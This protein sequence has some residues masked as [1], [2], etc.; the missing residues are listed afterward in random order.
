M[1]GLERY[2]SDRRMVALLCRKRVALASKNHHDHF[3]T[4]VAGIP[5]SRQSKAPDHEELQELLPPR[6]YWP[7]ARRRIRRESQD[8]SA[9]TA[10]TLARYVVRVL[11]EDAGAYAW[12]KRL[13]G[14]LDRARRSALSWNNSMVHNP[15]RILPIPKDRRGGG[16]KYRVV[17]T[18][19]LGD[20]VIASG[21]AA[22]LG[23]AID[24]ALGDFCFGSRP[25][26]DGRSRKHHDAVRGFRTFASQIPEKTDLWAAECDII[27]FFDSVPHKVALGK[28]RSISAKA[29][30]TLDDRAIA[31]LNSFLAGYDYISAR[32]EALTTLRARHVS[33]PILFDLKTALAEAG[34]ETN[35]QERRG[36]P[37]G[38]PLSGV[39][40]NAVLASADEACLKR[41]RGEGR[42][43]YGRF[44]DD[45]LLVST[46]RDSCRLALRAYRHE[47]RRLGLA[48][49]RAVKVHPYHGK[50]MKRFWEGKSKHPYL[51]RAGEHGSGVPWIGFLGYQFKRDGTLRI[52]RTSIQREIAKQMQVVNDV[53]GMIRRAHAE[54]AASRKHYR[55]P[56][57][58][59]I[60]HGVLMHLI[61]MGVGRPPRHRTSPSP[62][63]LCWCKGF[64]LLQNGPVALEPLKDLDRGRTSAMKTL[65]GKLITV[66]DGFTRCGPG[67]IAPQHAF[68]RHGVR[69]PH[70]LRYAGHTLS[71]Y[72][73]FSAVRKSCEGPRRQR[74]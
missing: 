36:I 5:A 1:F 56:A 68:E 51:W 54:A 38:S 50:G 61:A 27:G 33:A 73:Q 69:R 55:V 29:G 6:R 26:H 35:V 13:R 43:H 20:S 7:R 44:F 23:D 21:F 34:I 19:S 64:P 41:L 70:S 72:G 32:K 16:Q 46:K 40:A 39:I 63:S 47:L 8:R 2:F 74:E 58:H 49:H 52:R 45:I 65:R 25:C 9:T 71:Y 62:T 3:V 28:V 24:G 53:V 66:V 4:R 67:D 12:S 11:E 31:F 37:Q 30:V 42:W 10:K 17:V 18:Y 57:T 22:Y 15:R 14:F 60:E 59:R 48:H